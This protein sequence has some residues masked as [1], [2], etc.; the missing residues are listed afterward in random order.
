M[1][2]P[3]NI[4]NEKE[5]VVGL[6]DCSCGCKYKIYKTKVPFR[7]NDYIECT[8]CGQVIFKW[9]ESYTYRAELV[10]KFY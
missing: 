8:H 9:N 1:N 2:V 7:D 5:R 3:E 6:R 4:Q 10:G